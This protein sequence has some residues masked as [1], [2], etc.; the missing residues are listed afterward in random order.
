MRKFAWCAFVWL[1]RGSEREARQRLSGAWSWASGSKSKCSPKEEQ[2]GMHERRRKMQG[3]ASRPAWQAPAATRLGDVEIC[4]THSLL[5]CIPTSAVS[6]SL[7][8]LFSCQHERRLRRFPVG[9]SP[10]ATAAVVTLWGGWRRANR[11][12]T[13]VSLQPHTALHST[14]RTY[15]DDDH[16]AAAGGNG[17]SSAKYA[18]AAAGASVSR[19]NV[20]GVCCAVAGVVGV[21]L[22]G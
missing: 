9:R 7:P 3:W 2:R 18:E 12:R 6:S 13:P 8:P 19:T 17:C 21:C 16:E 22:A 14:K 15:S 11:S 10:A 20:C 5:C 4:L 1:A